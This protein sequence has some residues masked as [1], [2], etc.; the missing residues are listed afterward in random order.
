MDALSNRNASL[1]PFGVRSSDR[2]VARMERQTS[3][4]LAHIEQRALAQAARVDAVAYVGRRALMETAL[5]TKVE[6]DLAL[7]VPHAS[8]RLQMISDIATLSMAEVVAD[9][10]KK[11]R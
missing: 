10:V 11:L 4:E 7:L 6:Q 2:F 1:T 9:T 8:G 3:R 5:L